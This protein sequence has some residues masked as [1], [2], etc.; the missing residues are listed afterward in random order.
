[1]DGFPIESNSY[2]IGSE[3]WVA[4]ESGWMEQAGSDVNYFSVMLGG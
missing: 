2:E 4:F 3:L 1:M